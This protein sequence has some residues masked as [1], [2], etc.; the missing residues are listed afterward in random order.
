[1]YSK[2]SLIFKMVKWGDPF[3]FCDFKTLPEAKTLKDVAGVKVM[4]GH[5]KHANFNF[6]FELFAVCGINDKKL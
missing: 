4:T 6:S 1:M 3:S 5:S 2:G